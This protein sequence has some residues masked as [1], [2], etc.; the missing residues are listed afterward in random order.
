MFG[1]EADAAV[2]FAENPVAG[3]GLLDH[4]ADAGFGVAVRGGDR[5]LVRLLVGRHVPAVVAEHDGPHRVRHALGGDGG[6]GE[7]FVGA[8]CNGGGFSPWVRR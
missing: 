8:H 5:R 3:E 7:G 1:V 4:L 2:L 6:N